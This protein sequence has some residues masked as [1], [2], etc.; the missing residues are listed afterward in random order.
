MGAN[1]SSHV[2]PWENVSVSKMEAFWNNE[3]EVASS[4]MHTISL[5]KISKDYILP[6]V[7]ERLRVKG[8]EILPLI[9]TD[10]EW[11]IDED[12]EYHVSSST[13]N[14]LKNKT[15]VIPINIPGH[16]LMLVMKYKPRRNVFH[17]QWI[18]SS[19]IISQNEIEDI[20]LSI[21][22][23]LKIEEDVEWSSGNSC[24]HIQHTSGSCATWRLY[25]LCLTAFKETKTLAHLFD[26]KNFFSEHTRSF[27]TF[28][29]W[30]HSEIMGGQLFQKKLFSEDTHPGLRKLRQFAF[31][32]FL[33]RDENQHIF[34]HLDS[35]KSQDMALKK[36][37][38][39]DAKDAYNLYMFTNNFKIETQ[40]DNVG[41]D[42]LDPMFEHG[43][44][45]C[46]EQACG[47]FCY[48][49]KHSVCKNG[50]RTTPSK[51][52]PLKKKEWIEQS[53]DKHLL[54]KYVGVL[55]PQFVEK[56]EGFKKEIKDEQLREG[57]RRS[58]RM[59]RDDST[60]GYHQKIVAW[61]SKNV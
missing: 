60:R 61:L 55:D 14:N 1:E 41:S 13:L 15:V 44:K 16:A 21:K 48:S 4:L 18:D 25:F 20:V 36:I 59:K 40:L 56:I 8:V 30:I 10:K 37:V 35:Y 32:F 17:V 24:P 58:E 2:I 22:H 19:N 52:I 6:L 43:G 33:D 42:F 7:F 9:A 49:V 12:G 57:V 34:D 51:P 26:S 38:E 50:T 54:K 45:Q 23:C 53:S 5:D 46:G 29:F 27:K 31:G 11:K 39:N 3:F 47:Q 28:I